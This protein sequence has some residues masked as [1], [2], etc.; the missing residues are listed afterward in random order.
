[1]F[2]L[3]EFSKLFK[4]HLVLS[5]ILAF[6]VFGLVTSVQQKEII[7]KEF[8]LSQKTKMTPYFNALISNKVNL[9]GIK[10]KMINLPGVFEV[11]IANSKGL[12]EELGHLKKNFGSE[13]IGELSSLNYKKLKVQLEAGIHSKNQE[14]V[15]EYLSRLVGKDSLTMGAVKLPQ[16]IKLKNNDSLLVLV[17]HIDTYLVLFFMILAAISVFLLVKPLNNQAYII[18]K[19]QRKSKV[20]IKILMSGLFSIAAVS[21]I[22]NYLYRAEVTM[23]SLAVVAYIIVLPVIFLMTRKLNYKV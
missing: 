21:F 19:F 5:T 22:L 23:T 13:I 17:Q 3:K 1:M 12:N 4:S 9:D 16:D 14:L 2:Y 20:N 8:S 10:R 6:S 11:N 15:R 18:E 7:T